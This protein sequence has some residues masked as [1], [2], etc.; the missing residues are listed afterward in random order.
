MDKIPWWRTSFGEPELANIREAVLNERISQGSVT[1]Q[2]EDQFARSLGVPYGVAATSGSASILMA[3]M[4]LRIGTGDEVIVPNRTWIATAHAVLMTG[5]KVVLA[6]VCPDRPVLDVENLEAKITDRTRAV[7]AVHLN[8]RA[9]DMVS[10]ALLAEKHG[11]L[12]IEDA[13]QAL[14]SRTAEGYLGT[15][16]TVGCFSLAVTKLVS[17]GQGGM[18]VTKDPQVYEQL[19]LVRNHG[20]TDI[21]TDSWSQMGFNFKFT[22]LL[23]SFGLAQLQRVPG[24]LKHMQTIYQHY[25]AAM[26][27]FAFLTPVPIDVNDGEVPLYAEFF[28]PDRARL[29]DF[30]ASKNIQTR[31]VPPS[32]EISHYIESDG[33]FPNSKRF[34]DQAMYLPCGPEQPLEN[35]DRVIE[36]LKTF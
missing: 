1:K 22:D 16:S 3:L 12:V 36:T 5:A 15:L 9:T 27:D 4:A 34:A 25:L 6:D 7:I 18:V 17:T 2:F 26:R 8:G 14:Y 32:L 28:C 29:V 30:L 20:V 13:C 33:H 24:R 21:F 11:F 19:A 35:V 31:P 10:L 23:A